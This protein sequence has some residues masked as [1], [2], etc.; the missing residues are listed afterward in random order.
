MPFNDL[1]AN[2]QPYPSARIF[3][4]SVESLEK[5]K[6]SLGVLGVEADPVIADGKSPLVALLRRRD[7]DV[8]WELTP[9][10]KG[11]TQQVLKYTAQLRDIRQY[12]GQGIMGDHRPGVGNDPVQVL[13]DVRDNIFTGSF[14]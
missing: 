7:M 14:N 9:E 11:I 13:Q 12:D 4:A 1:L 5:D 10:L 2:G 8:R 3:T 6:D